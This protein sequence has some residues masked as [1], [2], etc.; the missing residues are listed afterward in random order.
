M[1][2]DSALKQQLQDNRSKLSPIIDTIIFC[3]RQDISLRGH[4]DSGLL[5]FKEPIEND[6]NFRAL[7]R[8]RIQSGDINLKKHIYHHH[9]VQHILVPESKMKLSI[10]VII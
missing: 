10:A 6:G 9:L 1:Q 4:R 2:L 3:G 7:L 5:D 8:L